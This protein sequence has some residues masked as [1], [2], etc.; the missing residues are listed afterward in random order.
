MPTIDRRPRARAKKGVGREDFANEREVRAAVNTVRDAFPTLET[1]EASDEWRV[2][3][4]R[5]ARW[6]RERWAH[7]ARSD[8]TWPLRIARIYLRLPELLPPLPPRGAATS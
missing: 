2:V 3:R 8:D 1:A 6:A 4:A 5:V 7:P